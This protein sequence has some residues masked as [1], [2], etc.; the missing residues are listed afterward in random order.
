MVVTGT[1]KFSKN[2]DTVKSTIHFTQYQTWTSIKIKQIKQ[3]DLFSFSSF[4]QIGN[5]LSFKILHNYHENRHIQEYLLLHCKSI[6]WSRT[7]CLIF[8]DYGRKLKHQH[9]A[10]SYLSWNHYHLQ[11]NKL[12]TLNVKNFY[13][14][15]YG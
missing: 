15:F 7:F 5:W 10:S 1:G 8:H 4:V 3:T 6:N 14:I 2:I 11:G 12:R 13:Q 9:Q